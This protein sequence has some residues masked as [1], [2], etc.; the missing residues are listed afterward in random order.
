VIRW[1]VAL[2]PLVCA[3]QTVQMEGGA[4]RVEGWQPGPEPPTGWSSVLAIYA[5]EGDVPPLV[6]AYAIE[7]GGLVFH[8]KYPLAPGMHVRAVFGSK[9]SASM[10][11]K[12]PRPLRPRAWSR[13]I[14]PPTCFPR[15][16]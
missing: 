9:E 2:I 14:R 10:C 15:I 5:G 3:A 13:F 8:P 16:N 6:G 11:R 12:R 7:D 4:F 1:F